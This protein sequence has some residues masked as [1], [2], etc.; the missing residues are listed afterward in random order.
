RWIYMANQTIAFR[1]VLGPFLRLWKLVRFETGRVLAGDFSRLP[2]WF[3]H[4]L[5]VAPVLY[6]VIAVCGMSL[7]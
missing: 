7:G 6:Y 4:A 1:V 3:W 2:T 5:S